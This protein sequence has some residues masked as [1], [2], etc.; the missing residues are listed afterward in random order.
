MN[1]GDRAAPGTIDPVSLNIL[2]G[3]PLSTNKAV[4]FLKPDN[5]NFKEYLGRVDHSFTQ[6]DRLSVRYSYNQFQRDAVFDPSN[7]LAYADGATIT[8]QNYLIHENHIFRPTLLTIF[9]SVM[10]VKTARRGPATTCPACRT[11]ARIFRFNRH[12]AIQQIRVNGFFN[13]GDNPKPASSGTTSPGATT[14]AG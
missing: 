7:F 8:N 1:S 5:E 6:N 9:A 14:S 12:N 13:F 3:L 4:T 2:A 10:R 11:W